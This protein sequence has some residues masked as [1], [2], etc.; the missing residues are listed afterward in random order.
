MQIESPFDALHEALASAVLIDLPD[1]EYWQRDWKAFRALSKELSASFGPDEGPGE[2]RK[3]RPTNEEVRVMMFAETWGSTACGYGGMGG[4]A[5]TP[6]YTVIV[7]YGGVSAVYFGCGRLAY[8]VD[9]R[10]QSKKGRERFNAD[11][12]R[13]GMA[14]C[15]Q[16]DRYK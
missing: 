1:I 10:D 11:I 16:E 15:G 5:M 4:A 7:S 3:R 9:H 2:L 14:S 8:L 6:A 12:S 13:P